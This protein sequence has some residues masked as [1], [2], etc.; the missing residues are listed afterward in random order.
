M[1]S[2]LFSPRWLAA[3]CL[4]LLFLAA[5]CS[6]PKSKVSGQVRINGTPL[7]GGL[8]T[9]R[10]ENSRENPVTAILDEQGKFSVVLPVGKVLVSIDNRHLRGRTESLDA[11]PSTLPIADDVRKAM[12]SGPGAA[13]SDGDSAKPTAQRYVPIPP[14]YHEVESSGLEFTVERGEQ[15]HDF[16]LSG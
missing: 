8:V 13:K 4:G 12:S 15:K 16:D 1:R 10:P 6:T 9:F 14:T 2:L 11:L 7:P 3:S 5:G